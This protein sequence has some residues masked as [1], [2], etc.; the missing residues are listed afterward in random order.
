MCSFAVLESE[1]ASRSLVLCCCRA[2]LN[3]WTWL[4]D[5]EMLQLNIGFGHR[6]LHFN[7]GLHDWTK[8]AESSVGEA[9]ET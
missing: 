9:V 1:S 7:I 3:S 5:D 6:A 4:Q 8:V 2:V